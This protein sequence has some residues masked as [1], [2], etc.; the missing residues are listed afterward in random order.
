MPDVSYQKKKT[1]YRY[2][3]TWSDWSYAT[4]YFAAPNGISLSHNLDEQNPNRATYYWSM[5]ENAANRLFQLVE[6]QS[7]LVKESNVTNG[8]S[9]AC[10]S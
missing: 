4:Y 1:I 2:R 7:I 5:N 9:L 8:A 10:N 6:Y 3:Y